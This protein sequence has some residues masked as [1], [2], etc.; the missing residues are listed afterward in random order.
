MALEKKLF[1]CLG[2]GQPVYIESYPDGDIHLHLEDDNIDCCGG[3]TGTL[4][5]AGAPWQS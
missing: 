1:E 4:A 2:C 3:I 5:I